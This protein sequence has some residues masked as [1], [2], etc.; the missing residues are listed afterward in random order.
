MATTARKVLG[1]TA[2]AGATD[3]VLYTVPALTD[4]VLSGISIAETGAA[5]ATIR[6]CVDTAGGTTTVA[7]KAIAWEVG[8]LANS[9]QV[10]G[11]GVTL[12]A[13]SKIIIRSSTATV[14]FSAFGQENS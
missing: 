2:P 13:A 14:T 10:I 11:R 7:G 9:T 8:I 6:V 3:T 5:P 4:V 1:Q 12:P